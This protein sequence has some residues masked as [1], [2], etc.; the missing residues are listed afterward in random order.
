MKNDKEQNKEILSISDYLLGMMVSL[1]GT[2]DLGEKNIN[3]LPEGA[4][5]KVFVNKYERNPINRKICLAH[6]GF[7]CKVCDFD[8]ENRYGEIGKNYIHVH[9]KIPVSNL[10]E[11]YIIDPINDLVP[12]CPNCHAMVHRKNPPIEVKELKILLKNA[13]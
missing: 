10:N 2:E 9:H 13:N 11:N 3:G 8:F 4:R 7:I 12:L 5:T 6:H 1:L